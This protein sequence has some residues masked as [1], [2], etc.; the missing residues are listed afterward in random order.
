MRWVICEGLWCQSA[1]FHTSRSV[2][3]WFSCSWLSAF[4]QL[5][6]PP[7]GP[8][9]S[10]HNAIFNSSHQNHS[11]APL[12]RCNET[13]YLIVLSFVSFL[14]LHPSSKSPDLRLNMR[15]EA[16]DRTGIIVLL[17]LQVWTFLIQMAFGDDKEGKVSSFQF[18]CRISAVIKSSN[19]MSLRVQFGL[20]STVG[21]MILLDGVVKSG[22]QSF[23]YC[24]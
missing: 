5:F 18:V 23:V 14:V 12:T 24:I 15:I 10:C 1:S 3:I 11:Q 17:L 19:R 2:C 8:Y 6:S 13:Y 21:T 22:D 16:T 20:E 7:M 4:N 9:V